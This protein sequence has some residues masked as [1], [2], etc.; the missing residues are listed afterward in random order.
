MVVQGHVMWCQWCM[1]GVINVLGFE[2]DKLFKFL[3]KTLNEVK[4]IELD[5]ENFE[6][7]K[8]DDPIIDYEREN[9]HTRLS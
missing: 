7:P 3:T 9:I 1:G 8:I 2:V 5:F 4:Y 6:A